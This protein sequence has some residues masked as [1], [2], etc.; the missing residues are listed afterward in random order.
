[1]RCADLVDT[2]ADL[3]GWFERHRVL[4]LPQ[5]SSTQ[6]L[7]R[8]DADLDHAGTAGADEVARAVDR[9]RAVIEHFDVRA[10]YVR[11]T[12]AGLGDGIRRDPGAVTVRLVAGGVVHELNLF[13]S[14]YVELL[15]EI[16]GL[17]YARTP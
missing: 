8:L 17:E 5:L 12:A 1:M 6:P 4:V 3:C 13:A 15:D 16:V 10:V 14:W 7:V 9:L 11:E 2:W